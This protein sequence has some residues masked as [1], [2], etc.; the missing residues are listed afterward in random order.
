[1]KMI[2][3]NLKYTTKPEIIVITLQNLEELLIVFAI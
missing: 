1:M 3:M 2:K